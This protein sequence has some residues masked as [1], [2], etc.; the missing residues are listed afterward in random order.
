MIIINFKEQGSRK[1]L[2]QLYLGVK[3]SIGEIVKIN[4]KDYFIKSIVLHTDGPSYTV[5]LKKI[6]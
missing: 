6:F 1:L 5:W 2:K 3:P 4:E